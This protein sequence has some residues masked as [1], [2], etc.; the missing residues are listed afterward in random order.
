MKK[1]IMISGLLS[2]IYAFTWRRGPLLTAHTPHETDK[3]FILDAFAI[4]IFFKIS[5]GS[6]KKLTIKLDG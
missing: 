4:V 2:L 1:P 5:R 6:Q 3:A